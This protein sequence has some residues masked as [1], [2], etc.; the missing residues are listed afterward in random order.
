MLDAEIVDAT[1]ALEAALGLL[2]MENG[3]RD[4]RQRINVLTDS[5]S[6]L[7]NLSTGTATTSLDDLSQFM[8]LSTKA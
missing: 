3:E 4:I 8:A 2:E 1:K 7:K 5:G 6:A